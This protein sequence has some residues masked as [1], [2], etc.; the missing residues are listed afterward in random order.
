[1]IVRIR[2]FTQKYRW[3]WIL[4]SAELIFILAHLVLSMQVQAPVS[5]SGSE[6][7]ALSGQ[8]V[9][10]D[11]Q[12]TISDSEDYGPF[13]QTPLITLK[14]GSYIA[15]VTYESSM[16]GAK[17][18]QDNDYVT[19]NEQ[20]LEA[21]NTYAS[22]SLWADGDTAT[23]FKFSYNGG[24]RTISRFTIV[25]THAYARVSTLCRLIFLAVLD[26]LILFRLGVLP[27][28]RV[29]CSS[30]IL[31][32]GLTALIIFQSMPL[33]T[34]FLFS[35]HDLPF[36][37]CRIQGIADGLSSGQFPVKIYPSLLQG[38]GYANGV[39]YGD[40]FLY[41]PAV[42][43]LF[44]FTLQT[45]YQ[46]YVLLVNI[47]TVLISYRC[48]SHIFGNR[49]CGFLG[50]ALYSLNLYRMTNLYT[51]AAV[52]EY[53]AMAFLPLILYALWGVFMLPV[54]DKDY[55]GLWLPG[56]VGYSGVILSHIL[57]CGVAA[58][59]TILTCLVCIRRVFRKQTFLVLAKIVIYTTLCCL[60]FLVP[61][62]DYM[63]TDK[64]IVTVDTHSIFSTIG[65]SAFPLQVLSLFAPATGLGLELKE[66]VMNDM[67]FTLGG[68][69]LISCLILPLLALEPGFRPDRR[70]K[71]AG[72]CFGFGAL[73]M[74]M[75]TTA[76]PWY[77][78]SR[79]I[80]FVDTFVSTM[81]F[82]WRFMSAAG[83]FMAVAAAAGFGMLRRRRQLFGMAMTAVCVLTL[84]VNGYYFHDL[85]ESDSS[86]VIYEMRDVMQN[87]KDTPYAK[88]TY[89]LGG[90]E[91]LPAGMDL[92][93]TWN[94][95]GLQY[96]A[97]DV[98]V[99]DYVK[100]GVSANFNAVNNA[101]ADR[102]VILPIVGYRDY[103]AYTDDGEL[104]LARAENGQ[105]QLTLP[106]GFSGHVTV[107]F[108]EPVY[109]RAAELFSLVCTAVLGCG[110]LRRRS[111]HAHNT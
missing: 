97:E 82:P 31:Y 40:L 15:S 6:L 22:F 100:T 27:T 30:R 67:G 64:L 62:A 92:D 50:S 69:L 2:N 14:K 48:F 51:R 53:T 21:G 38:Q 72:L 57:T 29:G 16:E 103:R 4:L 61:F 105:L 76:F 99:L 60:W 96:N 35:G 78:L 43:R 17:V 33:Y 73:C 75:S 46:I 90:A 98:T 41:I 94:M 87:A 77:Q 9:A 39:F 13:A 63:L 5:L 52:G 45:S 68:P 85:Y 109:W 19:M 88:L 12:I 3:F 74:W 20:V 28:G 8:A 42:L 86:Y 47:V 89:Q 81:Q 93:E 55:R 56:V 91:Y 66:G 79:F 111:R 24:V 110:Q 101:A 59:F 34:G 7:E 18:Y 106:A 32:A 37:L 84:C 26:L 11:G 70:A 108:T 95:T 23:S 71:A 44:G 65:Q 25:P 10:A 1:M 36:H 80:P 83:L 49:M 58:V 54:A 104:S 102:T 107:T